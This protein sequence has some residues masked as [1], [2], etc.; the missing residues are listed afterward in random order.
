[1]TVGL[2]QANDAQYTVGRVHLREHHQ[3]RAR[4]EPAQAFRGDPVADHSSFHFLRGAWC[5]KE[6]DIR[7]LV[8]FLHDFELLGLKKG[9]A[10]FHDGSPLIEDYANERVSGYP[11]PVIPGSQ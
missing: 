10:F 4:P 3:H 2:P 7:E 9:K 1:M 6:A 11:R 5:S 8:D